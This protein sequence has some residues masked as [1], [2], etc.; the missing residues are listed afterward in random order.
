MDE[1]PVRHAPDRPSK[2]EQLGSAMRTAKITK[3]VPPR[4]PHTVAPHV[5]RRAIPPVI[6]CGP[7]SFRRDMMLAKLEHVY[8]ESTGVVLF[9]PTGGASYG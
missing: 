1:K 9:P 5:G 8:Q 3:S 7:R 4:Q 6:Q 2:P